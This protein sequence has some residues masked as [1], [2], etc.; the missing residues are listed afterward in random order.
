M[1]TAPDSKKMQLEFIQFCLHQGALQVGSHWKL[2]SGRVSPYFFNLGKIQTGE[3]LAKL[4]TFY[5]KCIT[6]CF[7]EA[8]VLF[9]PAYKGIPVVTATAIALAQQKKSVGIA[10]NRKEAKEHGETGVLV[11]ASLKGQKVVIIDD[12]LTAG[13]AIREVLP[14]I[15]NAGGTLHG[16]V[17]A[18]NRQERGSGTVSAIQEFSESLHVSVKSLGNVSA[19]KVC[20][21]SLPN[22]QTALTEI[23]QYQKE[24]GAG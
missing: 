8:Q 12:V 4:G 3:G 15:S 1:I 13:T 10:Y 2:K 23:E 21:Q 5:A 11:G 19:L 7:P 9:G 16:I 20:L 14:L 17:I 6:D 18:F 24:Y 22:Y